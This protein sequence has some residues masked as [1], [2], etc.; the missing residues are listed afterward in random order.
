M[1]QKLW[2]Y[3]GAILSGTNVTVSVTWQSTLTVKQTSE[4]SSPE[5]VLKT[6][7]GGKLS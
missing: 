6:P 3:A 5:I 1:K 4:Q 2:D 7:Y